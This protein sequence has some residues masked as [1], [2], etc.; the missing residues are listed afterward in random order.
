MFPNDA[1]ISRLVGEVL[2]EQHEHWQLESRRMF[3]ADSMAAI[4]SLKKR[5]AL[6]DSAD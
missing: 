4:P 2:L 6:D 5:P 3:T 1:S